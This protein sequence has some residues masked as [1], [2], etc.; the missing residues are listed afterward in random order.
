M[1]DTPSPRPRKA[2]RE[3]STPEQIQ[4]TTIQHLI[5]RLDLLEGVDPQTAWDNYCKRFDDCYDTA[6]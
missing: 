4:C 1:S 2:P 5:Y 3:G 6:K